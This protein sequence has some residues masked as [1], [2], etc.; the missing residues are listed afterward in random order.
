MAGWVT[1]IGDSLDVPA[2]LEKFR[3]IFS[4]QRVPELFVRK[5]EHKAP[6]AITLVWGWGEGGWGAD[7]Y[8]ADN[9][10]Y[11]VVLHGCITGLGRFG[12]IETDQQD[13][14]DRILKLWQQNKQG[15]I[16]ELNGSFSGLIYD[17]KRDRVDIFVDRFASRPVWYMDESQR[18]IAGNF[19]SAIAALKSGPLKLNPAGLWSLLHT[20]RQVG[21]QG[22]YEGL[23]CLMAGQRLAKENS[24]AVKV[25]QWWRRK[26]EPRE[27]VSLREWSELIAE[28]L[29]QSASRYKRTCANPYLFLSGGL[30]SRVAA[31]AIESPVVGISLCTMPNAETRIAAMVAGKLGIKHECIVRS[32]YWYL[33]TMDPAALISGGNYFITHTHFIVPVAEI[34]GK[35][36]K[37]QFFLGDLLENFNKHY[38]SAT[39]KGVPRFEPDNMDRFLLDHVPYTLKNQQRLGTYL[40]QDLKAEC[41]ERYK[42]VLEQ[43]AKSIITVADD[44]A[45][46]FDTLLRWANVGITPTYNMLT[47]LHPLTGER[48]IR[49]D[50]QLDDLFSTIPP[51]VRGSGKLHPWTLFSL[52]KFLPFIPDA[53]NFLPP[54]LPQSFG[55]AAKKVRP[56][57]GRMRRNRKKTADDK[58]MLNTSG[59]WLLLDEMYRKDQRYRARIEALMNDPVVFPEDI[60]DRG[61]I[62]KAWTEFVA[63]NTGLSFEINALLSFATLNALIPLAGIKT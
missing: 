31:A 51:E 6:K 36:G 47:C 41:H 15:I 63:G 34:V 13:V 20:G 11:A 40:R 37:A 16:D 30:D 1:L 61:E 38:F 56:L 39:D 18:I 4:V 55:K 45:S 58:P 2:R 49:F 26:Y 24:G 27:G 53:N 8:T 12:A 22:L 54:F 43:Y 25:E 17:K 3:S 35:E 60:F 48:N 42:S 57:L 23:Y 28:S 46:R 33:E 44:D 52:N 7:L 21:N 9:D 14:A 50:N 59:S 5:I 10:D 29:R 62:S 19:P 32:P